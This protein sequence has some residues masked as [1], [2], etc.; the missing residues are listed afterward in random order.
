[1]S[2]RRRAAQLARDGHRAWAKAEADAKRKKHKLSDG[3]RKQLRETANR[4][5]HDASELEAQAQRI[6]VGQPAGPTRPPEGTQI[7]PPAPG[8]PDRTGGQKK[9]AGKKPAAKKK[10][11]GKK[12]AAKKGAAKKPAG[13][14]GGK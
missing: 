12:P 8:H 7:H 1:V 5:W 6:F 3:E 9:P 11:A 13:K 10:P 4:V 2:L 14:K